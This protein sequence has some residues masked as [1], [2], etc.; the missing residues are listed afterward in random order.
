MNRLNQPCGYFI[1]TF[2]GPSGLCGST[3]KWKQ[4]IARPRTRRVR[5]V[6]CSISLMNRLNQKSFLFQDV[7]ALFPKDHL[8]RLFCM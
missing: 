5:D 6:A 2:S 1:F 4:R 8:F 3:L 7:E